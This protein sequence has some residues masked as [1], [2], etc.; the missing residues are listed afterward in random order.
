MA[1]SAVQLVAVDQGAARHAEHDDVE[2][3]GQ[4]RPQVHLKQARGA[5][6][7]SGAVAPTA[8]TRSLV[9][10]RWCTSAGA[11]DGHRSHAQAT[12]G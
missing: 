1:N 2:A 3:D 12:V 10:S 7:A 5:A 4:A 11:P 9:P 8:S 6:T